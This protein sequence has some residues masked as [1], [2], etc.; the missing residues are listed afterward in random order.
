MKDNKKQI[1]IGFSILIILLI[2]LGILIIKEMYTYSIV[3]ITL[4]FICIINLLRLFYFFGKSE[5]DLYNKVLRTILNT[6]DSVLVD[7]DKIPEV[8]PK[9]IIK[10]LSFEKMVDIQA[11]RKKPIF[12]KLS[13][14]SCLFLILDEKEIYVYVLR[15]KEDSYSPLDDIIKTMEQNTEKMEKDKL[16]LENIEKT[17][18]IKLDNLKEY[19]VSP[20]H[21][22]DVLPIRKDQFLVKLKK[23]YLKKKK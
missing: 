2:V 13:I 6:Y 7:I 5:E 19:K 15:M 17:T 11:E 20:I 4:L 12:Y 23:D 10:V 9:N 8:N 22:E 1:C 14:N 21:E 16:L 18:I 3:I